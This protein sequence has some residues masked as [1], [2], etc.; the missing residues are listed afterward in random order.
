[1]PVINLSKNTW[2]ATK[3]FRADSFLTR[4]VGLLN[5]KHLGPEE[6]LVLTPCKGVHTIGMKFPIDVIFLDKTDKV[7]GYNSRLRPY[8]I[9]G[10]YPG[11]TIAVELLS[12]SI[13]KSQTEIGDRLE[14]SMEEPA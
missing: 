6:A 11:A 1:M 10:I 13:D 5:R 14:I 12:G 4:L 9:S 2:L 3:V 7:L 8:R